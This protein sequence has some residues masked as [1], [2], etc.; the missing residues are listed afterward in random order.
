MGRTENHSF[1][2]KRV[3]DWRNGS[4]RL[5]QG[6]GNIAGPVRTRAKFSH[7]SQV[8]LFGGG[9]SVKADPK[10]TRIEFRQRKRSGEF[11]VGTV[12]RRSMSDVP[13]VFAPFLEKI[14]VA[15]RLM[16]NFGNRPVLETDQFLFGRHAQRRASGSRIEPVD[17]HEF[18]QSFSVGFCPTGLPYELRQSGS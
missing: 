14:G 15:Q 3:S 11:G 13:T 17:R 9:Q 2:D 1:G 4:D 6:F 10:K 5:M 12:D 18:E 7:R 8:T 16:K